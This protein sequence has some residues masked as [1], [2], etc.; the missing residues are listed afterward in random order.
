MTNPVSVDGRT[1][2]IA[3]VEAVARHGAG[4]TLESTA[5]KK[6][7]EARRVVKDILDSVTWGGL[8]LILRGASK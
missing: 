5:R 2:D 4:V 7:A 8:E 3:G 1:L 6:V